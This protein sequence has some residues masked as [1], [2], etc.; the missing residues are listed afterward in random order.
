MEPHVESSKALFI[1]EIIPEQRP[2]PRLRAWT[3]RIEPGL[4]ARK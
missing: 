3:L 1:S 4:N 2:P